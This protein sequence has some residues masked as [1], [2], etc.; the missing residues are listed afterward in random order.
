MEKDRTKLTVRSKVSGP[1]EFENAS[2][3]DVGE[4]GEIWGME[5]KKGQ[6]IVLDADGNQL[7]LCQTNYGL[8]S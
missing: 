4:T 5:I 7:R 8:I 6:F 3:V 2:V 1:R